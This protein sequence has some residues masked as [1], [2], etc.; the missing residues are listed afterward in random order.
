[1]SMVDAV[2]MKGLLA[3]IKPGTHL[4][5]IGDVDQLPPVG[6]GKVLE[7]LIS[8]ELISTI[9]L[10]QIFRQAKESHIVMNAHRINNGEE[11]I[12]SNEKTD[13]YFIDC[14]REDKVASLIV[15]L[16]SK[17]IP[18]AFGLDPFEHIQVITPTRKTFLGTKSLNALLQ[19]R[20]NPQ[21]PRKR[22]Y[23]FRGAVFRDGDRIMQTRNNYDLK[24]LKDDE[25]GDGIFNGDM[26][27]IL[28][29]YPEEEY[30]EVDF[31]GRIVDYEFS[32]L[33]DLVHSYAVTVHKSQGS[34][35]PVVIMPAWSFQTALM[36][37]KLLYTG[38][39]RAKKMVVLVGGKYNIQKMVNNKYVSKRYTALKHIIRDEIV[40]K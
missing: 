39:T 24:W 19:E 13:F 28:H 4:V 25:E 27:V 34:E 14:N 37:R 29:I 9:R 23:E 38:V 32:L 33:E 12:Y 6:A 18:Q 22:E 31:D 3:A 7:D 5:M 30:M 15:D 10:T 17:R 20:L 1:M 36:T 40:L 8:S 26:G 2:L 21:N 16:A 35:Y 11:L